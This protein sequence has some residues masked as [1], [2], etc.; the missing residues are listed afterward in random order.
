MNELELRLV[1]GRFMRRGWTT[2]TCAAAAAGAAAWMLLFQQKRETCSIVTPKGIT[3]S[4]KV[5]EPEI[6]P[7]S[8]SCGIRKDAGDDPDVTQGVMVYAAVRYRESGVHI[9]GGEGIG[10]VTKPG[11][12]QP[13]GNAAINSTPRKMI[14]REC[15]KAAAEA[16]YAGGFDVIISIPAGVEIASRT[17][18][19]R[20]GITG[21][22]SILGTSGIVEPM[23]ESGYTESIRLEL[24][25]RYSEGSRNALFTVGNFAAAFAA[26]ELGLD[27][28]PMVKCSNFIGEAIDAA[29][30]IGFLRCLLVGHIGK[31]VKMGIGITNTHSSRGDGRIETLIA[32]A[33]DAGGDLELLRNISGCVSTDAALSMLRRAGFLES[34]MEKLRIRME[35][36]IKRKSAGLLDAGFVCFAKKETHDS[37]SN[38]DSKKE[39]EIVLQS[40][41]A[42]ALLEVFKQ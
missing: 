42:E 32:C 35:D 33:L 9:D 17:F 26:D 11:L 16:A 36:T 12:D 23:S 25:Q 15:E 37:N 20:V 8:A 13:V 21:G 5:E 14:A 7:D 24:R 40:S 30:E 3:L 4:L 28:V 22:I 19:P 10:R 38:S 34:T 39:G 41:N 31:L 6:N 18:N 27:R 29:A 1:N 2:G